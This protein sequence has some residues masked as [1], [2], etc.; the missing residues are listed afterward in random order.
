MRCCSRCGHAASTDRQ[1]HVVVVAAGA[2]ESSSA[3]WAAR[4]L[5]GRS[6]RRALDVIDLSSYRSLPAAGQQCPGAVA[7]V[8]SRSRRQA[9]ASNGSR[10]GAGWCCRKSTTVRGSG[11]GGVRRPAAPPR[12]V[13]RRPDIRGS[14]RPSRRDDG[15]APVGVGTLLLAFV[16]GLLGL[17]ALLL[18]VAA[19][20]P[21]AVTLA[22]GHGDL[23]RAGRAL[24][25]REG[26][27]TTPVGCRG[28]RPGAAGPMPGRTSSPPSVP[29]DRSG[30]PRRPRVRSRPV[31]LAEAQHEQAVR[32]RA[33]ARA[34]AAERHLRCPAPGRAARRRGPGL[35]QT[36]ELHGASPGLQ[37]A[38]ADAER[39]QL[40]AVV[41]ATGSWPRSVPRTRRP[42]SVDSPR[43]WRRRGC[44][45]GSARAGGSGAAARERAEA[46]R[47]AERAHELAEMEQRSADEADGARRMAEAAASAIDL[48]DEV[49]T[50]DVRVGAR[51]TPPSPR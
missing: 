41:E 51:G 8:D 38:P 18:G 39:A 44:R 2:D 37:R 17:G 34:R 4:Q 15:F 46:E 3:G 32:E 45:A 7:A 5:A 1:Q 22:A 33:A 13:G 35:L 19:R 23:A 16:V 6:P 12:L 26:C 28:R 49:T 50:T 21:R 20:S 48:R 24:R 27:R 11:D 36:A 42:T 30:S 25:E 31:R 10:T 29:T 47:A 40:A 14:R 43:S 9:T